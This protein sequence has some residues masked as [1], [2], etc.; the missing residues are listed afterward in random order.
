MRPPGPD[1]PSDHFG[2]QSI[3]EQFTPLSHRHSSSIISIESSLG[4]GPGRRDSTGGHSIAS[5][6][7]LGGSSALPPNTRATSPGR[8]SMRAIA[9]YNRSQTFTQVVVGESSSTGEASNTPAFSSPSWGFQRPGSTANPATTTPHSEQP[10][11]HTPSPEE[12][13]TPDPERTGRTL[14]VGTNTEITSRPPTACSTVESPPGPAMQERPNAATESPP[15][16]RDQ[17]K[18]LAKRGLAK[19]RKAARKIWTSQ[20]HKKANQPEVQPALTANGNLQPHDDNEGVMTEALP[21]V[22]NTAC[23]SPQPAQQAAPTAVMDEG[24][25][26]SPLASSTSS[27]SLSSSPQVIGEGV[28]SSETNEHLE[29]QVRAVAAQVMQPTGEPVVLTMRLT[30]PGRAA[31]NA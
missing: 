6:S 31:G 26:P 2:F 23:P 14:D 10:D 12:S 13:I 19:V 28:I 29:Q 27:I 21:R 18:A 24:N 16:K 7:S 4:L 17:L 3:G 5:N 20:K 9:I 11:V 15:R 8:S 30:T 25:S 22:D 1:H